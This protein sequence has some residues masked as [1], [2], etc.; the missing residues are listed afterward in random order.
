MW[1][2]PDSDHDTIFHLIL[3]LPAWVLIVILVTGLF[4]LTV[5]CFS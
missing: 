1:R 5:K 4:V 3:A 2:L